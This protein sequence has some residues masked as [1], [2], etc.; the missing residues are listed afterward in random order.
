MK[1]IYAKRTH[2]WQNISV[3][4]TSGNNCA[5]RGASSRKFEAA[6]LNLSRGFGP[7][8][9]GPLSCAL[10]LVLRK[11]DVH[12]ERRDTDQQICAWRHRDYRLCSM[13]S[14]SL[15]LIYKLSRDDSIN[16]LHEDK[17]EKASW[18]KIP[19]VDY[20]KWGEQASPMRQ[21]YEATGV[22]ASKI[23]HDRTH[24]LQYGGAEGL[25]PY[26]LHSMSKHMTEKFHRSYQSEANKEVSTG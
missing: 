16:F 18:W 7:E 23:T 14:L 3:A 11:G 25:M 19:I 15:S 17:Y 10:M 26:Q 2:D 22:I 13:F 5:A 24:A 12:K 6:D 4:H 21:I 8:R 1:Y 9:S 20:E